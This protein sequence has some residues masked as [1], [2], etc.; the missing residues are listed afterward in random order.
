M[1]G[2][3]TDQAKA[4]DEFI[5]FLLNP[6][7]KEMKLIGRGGTG[8]SHLVSDLIRD[9][10]KTYQENCRVLGI[11]PEYTNYALT[12]MTNRAAQ[13]LADATGMDVTTVHSFLSLTIKSNN[14]SGKQE[15]KRTANWTIRE[16]ML[17]FV[18]ES[19]S[20]MDGKLLD[21]LRAATMNCKIV[22]IGDD[23]QLEP[24]EAA[25]S[26]VANLNVRTSNLT[27]SMRHAL[28]PDGTPAPPYLKD[29]CDLFWENVA[30]QE[31]SNGMAPWPMIE[32]HPGYIDHVDDAGLQA[33]LDTEFLVPNGR[34]AIAAF[35]NSKVNDYNRYL[36]ELRGMDH[37]FQAGERLI[38]NNM[39]ELGKFRISNEQT[40]EIVE[41][42]P[43]VRMIKLG[44]LEIP[45]QYVR[46]SADPLVQIP[47][48]LD[49]DFMKDAIKY[50]GKKAAARQ[51]DWSRYWALQQNFADFRPRDAATIHKLQGSTKDLVVVDLNNI[52]ACNFTIMVA[53]LLYVALSRARYRLVLYGNLP[54][55]YGGVIF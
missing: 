40:V 30:I 27:I 37:L 19:V 54:S 39:F 12:A 8:K 1:T 3:N 36:R 17:I 10:L 46:V 47:V 11:E 33:L 38:S 51:E 45:T 26:P 28:N 9:A 4:K 21:E 24:I 20:M 53:R 13:E 16:K 7:E 15:L 52:G 42:D 44:D 6:D 34:N 25:K 41:A 14:T 55:K 31:A 48:I 43:L 50:V 49:R 23:R 29:L 18:D 32:L 5:D 35:S 22:F 2:L